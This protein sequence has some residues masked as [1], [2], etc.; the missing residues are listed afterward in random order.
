[1]GAQVSLVGDQTGHR[2]HVDARQRARHDDRFL[3]SV[4][5]FQVGWASGNRMQA[6]TASWA[7]DFG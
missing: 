5:A 7:W 6:S 2:P 3:A 4:C 1:M